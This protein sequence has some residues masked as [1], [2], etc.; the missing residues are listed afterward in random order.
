MTG[1]DGAD[2]SAGPVGG[3]ISAEGISGHST[4]LYPHIFSNDFEVFFT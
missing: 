4:Q 3:H 1:I 2:C